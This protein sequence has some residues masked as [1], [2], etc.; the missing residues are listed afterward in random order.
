LKHILM[1][2][3]LIVIAGVLAANEFDEVI[4]ETLCTGKFESHH[5][6][7]MFETH[8]T[9]D[10]K[11]EAIELLANIA[12]VF[13]AARNEG[14][15]REENKYSAEIA[16]TDCLCVPYSDSDSRQRRFVVIKLNQ[17]EFGIGSE[18]YEE[19]WSAILDL[20]RVKVVTKSKDL[21]YKEYDIST[22]YEKIMG[23][24]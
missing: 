5:Y 8:H 22:L 16:R 17:I 18:K 7:H 21:S 13:V 12:V 15:V 4:D 2:F 24:W 9:C 14:W 10:N 20:M 23:L 11:E 1:F 6:Q 19:G 3:L